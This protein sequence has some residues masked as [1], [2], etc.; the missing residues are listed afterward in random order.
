MPLNRRISRFLIGSILLL[1]VWS[2]AIAQ[3]SAAVVKPKGFVADKIIAKI[4]NYI[5][6]R[7]E[8]EGAFQN[9]LANGGQNNEEAKCGIFSQLVINKLLVAKAEID[10]VL[11]TDLEVDNNTD[12]R[13]NMIM[14]QSGNSPEQLE[15]AYGK[16]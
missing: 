16:T 14:Q 13:M 5:I 11:I 12:Q 3:D 8:L 6:L 2:M 9:Y 10:S 4:D 1:G 15:A 7:S